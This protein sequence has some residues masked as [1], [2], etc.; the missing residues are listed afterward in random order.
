M[1]TLKKT[2]ITMLIIGATLFLFRGG[3]FR[4]MVSYENSGTGMSYQ[5]TSSDLIKYLD[6]NGSTQ[7]NIDQI[8][9]TSL[10]LTADKLRFTAD[11]ND[12]NPNDLITTETAHCVGYATFCATACNY[13]LRQNSLNDT[14]KAQAHKGQ[15]YVFGKNVHQFFDSPFFKDHDFVIIE[16]TTTGAT[17]AVDPSVYDYLWVEKVTLR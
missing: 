9:V 6:E 17:I 5:A 3:L 12:N 16:N 8:I 7:L 15:L 4:F 14:W 13:L 1:K 2:F 11:A 10:D